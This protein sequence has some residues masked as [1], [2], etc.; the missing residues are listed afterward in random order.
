MTRGKVGA[1]CG[2]WVHW[3]LWSLPS[4]F[5]GAYLYKYRCEK[6]EG[7]YYARHNYTFYRMNGRK[8]YD[9]FVVVQTSRHYWHLTYVNFE[10]QEY[11]YFGDKKTERIARRMWYIYKIDEKKCENMR[12][13][14]EKTKNSDTKMRT[15]GQ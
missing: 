10:R 9:V 15:R 8:L 12:K 1:P 5:K 13:N 11:E 4:E 2:G 7:E 3:L 14:L 6:Q